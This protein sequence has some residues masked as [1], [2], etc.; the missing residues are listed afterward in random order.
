MCQA[1]I[2]IAPVMTHGHE[3]SATSFPYS[4]L[5]C[6]DYWRNTS[7]NTVVVSAPGTLDC[8]IQSTVYNVCAST[9]DVFE[10]APSC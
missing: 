4:A 5:H 1:I 7:G 9:D 2:I 6:R 3:P 8:T 10:K